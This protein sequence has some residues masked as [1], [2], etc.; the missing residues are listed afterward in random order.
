MKI[1]EEKSKKKFKGKRLLECGFPFYTPN[2]YIEFSLGEL[3]RFVS[4][5]EEIFSKEIDRNLLL[6]PTK[7]KYRKKIVMIKIIKNI[8]GG[9]HSSK[10]RGNP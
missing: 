10:I 6:I 3:K 5:S 1:Q 2:F 9:E 8:G 7:E 4:L